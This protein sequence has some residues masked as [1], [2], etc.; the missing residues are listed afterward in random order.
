[1]TGREKVIVG[2]TAVVLV[3]A[4]V[5]LVKDS[6]GGGPGTAVEPSRKLQDAERAAAESQAQL[7][8]AR[9]NDNERAALDAAGREWTGRPFPEVTD[10]T[11]VETAERSAL[12]YTGFVRSGDRLFAVING[13]EYREQ[14]SLPDGGGIIES[15]ARDQIVLKTGPDGRRLVIP[16]TESLHK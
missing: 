15:I 8:A 5:M 1:M 12:A 4:G 9:L 14:E 13:R 6:L 3:W 11:R 2:V 10:V 16:F 7:A